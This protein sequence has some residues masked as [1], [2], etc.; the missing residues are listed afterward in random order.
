MSE[1]WWNQE[2]EKS[3][4]ELLPDGEYVATLDDSQFDTT[5]TPKK[6]KVQYL[7]HDTKYGGR[8]LWQ[9]FTFNEKSA[10][11]LIWQMGVIGAHQVAK[12]AGSEDEY[13]TSLAKE[14]YRLVKENA[15]VLLEV[16]RREYNGK[17]YQNTIIKEVYIGD[18]PVKNEA[19][20]IEGAGSPPKT[21][22]SEE[23]P[24]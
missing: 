17:E 10:K 18:L 20:N 9:N 22:L 23:L 12:E 4:Y 15:K 2:D 8:K 6:L 14:V 3:S 5:V 7:V 13:Y 1:E 16:T 11:F 24:F 21:D 19:L